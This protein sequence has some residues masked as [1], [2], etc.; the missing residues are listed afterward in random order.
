[1]TVT[2]NF[3]RN[4]PHLETRGITCEIEGRDRWREKV[5]WVHNDFYALS[6]RCV[7]APVQGMLTNSTVIL[8][9][10][11]HCCLARGMWSDSEG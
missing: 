2:A 4:I 6:D 11:R 8:K 7:R 9:P 1:M 5:V 3:P 10:K